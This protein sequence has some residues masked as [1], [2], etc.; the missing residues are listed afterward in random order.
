MKM[1][2]MPSLP[3]P[4]L[5]FR[6]LARHIGTPEIDDDGLFG[7]KSA[8]E[9]ASHRHQNIFPTLIFF[10][11]RPSTHA[12]VSFFRNFVVFKA[13][14]LPLKYIRAPHPIPSFGRGKV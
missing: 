1:N 9:L 3:P 7:A 13:T 11:L 14:L 6:L 4:A 12:K 10:L 8:P 2:W 5:P